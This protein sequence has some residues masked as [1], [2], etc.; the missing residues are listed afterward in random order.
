VAHY[1]ASRVP[2]LYCATLVDEG[3]PRARVHDRFVLLTLTSGHARVWSRGETHALSPGA[4][5]MLEPGDVDRDL[6]KSPYRAV[7]VALKADVVETLRGRHQGLRLGASVA[8]CSALCAESVSLVEVVRAGHERAVQERQLARLFGL[9]APYWARTAPR[10]EPPLV[11][12]ARRALAKSPRLSL[13][14]LAARLR[15]A[16][17]YL[18]RVFSEHTGVGPHAYQLQQRL[19]EAGRLIEGGRSVAKAA[20]LT[21][22]GD[23]S[24]LRRHFHRRFAAAPGRYQRE[25]APEIP[26]RV[27]GRVVACEAS[28][29]HGH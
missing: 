17:T 4:V 27:S 1:H 24:H 14:E 21:G 12:R 2:G 11:T 15:C 10:P 3:A 13:G 20:T 18:C 26:G 22:F 16:P 6:Q 23:A 8:R 5:L 7:M 25:L 19:L 9:L 29:A 28:A